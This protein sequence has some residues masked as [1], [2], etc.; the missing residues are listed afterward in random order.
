MDQGHLQLF[1]AFLSEISIFLHIK[2]N[3]NVISQETVF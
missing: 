1:W 2:V 3:V